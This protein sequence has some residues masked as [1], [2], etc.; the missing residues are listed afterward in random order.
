MLRSAHR[1][2]YAEAELA[3]K[4]LSN[5]RITGRNG[6]YSYSWIHDQLRW[7]RSIV[8]ELID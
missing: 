8:Q 4:K 6:R 3:L 7:A 2:F 1:E 5:L